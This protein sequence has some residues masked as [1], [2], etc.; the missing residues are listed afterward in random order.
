M[1]SN[2]IYCVYYMKEIYFVVYK[3][4]IVASIISFIISLFSSGNVSY[5]SSISGYST[6][7]LG[8]MM[9]LLNFI[10]N[11]LKITAGQ[12]MFRIIYDV[13]YVSGP[14]LFLLMIIGFMLYIIIN[15]QTIII[16][17]N[18]SNNYYLFTNI[19]TV[20][21]MLQVYVI[22]LNIDNLNTQGKIN[23]VT[24]GLLYL[25]VILTSI[26]S[27]IVFT[28]LKYFTTDGFSVNSL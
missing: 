26:S 10:Q 3:A 27:I 9:I 14:F 8:I 2:I 21:I 16:S 17:G 24:S 18:I 23:K 28:I 1:F 7:I 6:L 4:F 22:Y 11:I 12:S 5:G 19:V 25:L 15:Y 20:L 13:F